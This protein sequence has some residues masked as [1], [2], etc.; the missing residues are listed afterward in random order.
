MTATVAST[1]ALTNRGNI[2]VSPGVITGNTSAIIVTRQ[3][4]LLER[5]HS[6]AKSHRWRPA[7]RPRAFSPASVTI[8]GAA[9]VPS[10]LALTT[11]ATTTA[12]LVHPR[13]SKAPWFA[14]GESTLA[15]ALL[16]VAPTRRRRVRTIVGVILLFAIV[17]GGIVSYGGGSTSSGGVGSSLGTTAGAM[18]LP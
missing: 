7:I 5:P 12:A 6:L 3:V 4:G 1:F 17:V 16:F 14:A 13:P 9:A 8:S 15:C 11:T 2:T 10:A 18:R